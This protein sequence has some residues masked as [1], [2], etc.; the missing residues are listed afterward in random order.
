MAELQSLRT[1]ANGALHLLIVQ[2]AKQAG[3]S[4]RSTLIEWILATGA[5]GYHP[6]R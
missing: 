4:T 2:Y 6:V 1:K 3:G 5:P